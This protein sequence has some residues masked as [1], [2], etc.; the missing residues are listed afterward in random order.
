MFALSGGAGRQRSGMVSRLNSTANRPVGVFLPAGRGIEVGG[1]AF[2]RGTKSSR[3]IYDRR[4]GLRAA[5]LRD[6][7]KKHFQVLTD[8]R[9]YRDESIT[10]SGAGLKLTCLNGIIG[11]SQLSAPWPIAR[12]AR[13]H[14]H[15]GLGAGLYRAGFRRRTRGQS[16]KVPLGGRY[17]G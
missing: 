14:L 6:S 2:C 8:W 10:V 3:G 11:R 7:R 5:L 12:S 13:S 1:V 9:N 16:Q 4:S 17:G 15:A